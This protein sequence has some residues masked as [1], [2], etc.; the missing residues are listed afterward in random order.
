MSLHPDKSK[1]MLISAKNRIKNARPLN[2]FINNI[3]IENVR[4][5][6]ILGVYIDNALTW[7][8]QITFVC[9][10][11]K[12]KIALMKQISSFLNDDMKKKFYNVYLVPCFDYC[13]TVWGKGVHSI[14]SISKISKLQKRAAR[15]ILQRPYNTNSLELFKELQ[16]VTFENRVTYHAAMM[17][18]KSKNKLFPDY[19]SNLLTFSSNEHYDLRSTARNDLVL[20][21]NRTKYIKDSFSYHASLIWNTLPFNLRQLNSLYSFKYNLRKF[22]LNMQFP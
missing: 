22:I 14:G 18:F 13:C 12:M 8:M 16:W 19:M 11:I 3:N 7:D 21:G 20:P 2:L 5:Q 4:V 10:Q 15:I 1:C 6:K 17:V 9:K